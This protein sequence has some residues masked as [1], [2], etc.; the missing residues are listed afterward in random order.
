MTTSTLNADDAFARFLARVA[1]MKPDQT[2]GAA[3]SKLQPLFEAR[4]GAHAVTVAPVQAVPQATSLLSIRRGTRG[5]PLTAQLA[6]RAAAIGQGSSSVVG[7]PPPWATRILS[8]MTPAGWTAMRQYFGISLVCTNRTSAEG[9]PFHLH[10]DSSPAPWR[11]WEEAT[12]VLS[13]STISRLSKSFLLPTPIQMQC[14]PLAM[15]PLDASHS[16]R[17]DV[18]GIAETGSGKTLCYV[19]PAVEH[20]NKLVAANEYNGLPL[21]LIVLPTRELADQVASVV[22][23]FAPDGIKIA[24]LVGGEDKDAQYKKLV[25]GVHLVVGT[26]GQLN[27]LLEDQSL[28]LA[29]ASFVAVDEADRMVDESLTEQLVDV[30]LECPHPRQTLLFTATMLDE[31]A[32]IA[33][34]FLSPQG[35]YTVRTTYRFAGLEQRFEVFPVPSMPE[36]RRADPARIRRLAG[37]LCAAKPPVI[38][39]VNEKAT[40]DI[41][42]DQL[43]R[44]RQAAESAEDFFP[45]SDSLSLSGGLGLAMLDGIV[46][47]HSDLKHHQRMQCVDGLRR[48]LY[49]VLV[50]TDLLARGL[51]IS[52]VTLVVNFELPR[53][54]QDRNDGEGSFNHSDGAANVMRYIH[55]IGRTARGGQQGTAIS[56]VLLP[57]KLLT[58][59]AL[60]EDDEERRQ[61]KRAR[62]EYSEE[63]NSS[64]CFGDVPTL[65]PLYKFLLE[66]CGGDD[67]YVFAAQDDFTTAGSSSSRR[68]RAPIVLQQL[69][70]SKTS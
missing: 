20:C 4:H 3:L 23:E 70:K 10:V 29:K 48:G 25:A 27:A 40:A 22:S 59:A 66:C 16:H 38:V 24:K 41:L 42:V 47:V 50:T 61:A 26:P 6:K 15:T 32:A 53:H 5:D 2:N 51:D 28:V 45:P 9:T 34:R 49:K 13:A 63:I 69:M 46:A 37:L 62:K 52:G 58:S 31:C 43:A 39:F 54:R 17:C 19:L 11:C 57:N 18:L 56:F 36:E 68:V 8:H 65:Q 67:R 35:Y 1:G 60:D 64:E 44:M 30:L 33:T 21:A 12:D 55:R 14:L 7:G